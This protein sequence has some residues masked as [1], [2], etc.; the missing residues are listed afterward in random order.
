[1]MYIVA[2]VLGVDLLKW[3]MRGRRKETPDIQV[4]ATQTVCVTAVPNAG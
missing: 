4:S 1:M 2:R 3:N